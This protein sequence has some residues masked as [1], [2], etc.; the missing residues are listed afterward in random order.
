MTSTKL[1]TD[2]LNC[3]LQIYTNHESLT[4][5]DLNLHWTKHFENGVCFLSWQTSQ[6][7]SCHVQ[8]RKLWIIQRI[9]LKNVIL[10]P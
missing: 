1:R 7:Q 8:M 5:K 2:A 10:M 4:I 6:I 3:F 9:S